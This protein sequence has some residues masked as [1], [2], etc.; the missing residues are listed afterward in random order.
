[1]ITDVPSPLTEFPVMAFHLLVFLNNEVLELGSAPNLRERRRDE[2]SREA[3]SAA[4]LYCRAGIIGNERRSLQSSVGIFQSWIVNWKV[5][6][7][8]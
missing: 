2:W 6:S 7:T 1:M 5:A 4:P 3:G 8:E